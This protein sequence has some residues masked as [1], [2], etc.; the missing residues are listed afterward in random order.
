[1]KTADGGGGRPR[2][3]RALT[4][5]LT[6]T[7]RGLGGHSAAGGFPPG[8]PVPE[9]THPAFPQDVW[10]AFKLASDYRR[11]RLEAAVAAGTVESD[12]ELM[13]MPNAFKTALR[14]LSRIGGERG[15]RESVD[16]VLG[17]DRFCLLMEGY[18]IGFA[19]VPP[20]VL[21]TEGARES[22]SRAPFHELAESLLPRPHSRQVLL[23]SGFGDQIL[24]YAR[25]CR[26]GWSCLGHTRIGRIF[27]VPVVSTGRE[28]RRGFE[29]SYKWGYKVLMSEVSEAWVTTCFEEGARF[30]V[31]IAGA[32]DLSHSILVDTELRV[33]K[34]LARKRRS[35]EAR[36]AKKEGRDVRRDPSIP[37]YAVTGIASGRFEEHGPYETWRQAARF[38]TRASGP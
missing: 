12:I 16:Y 7:H 2:T 23:Y 4:S 15:E 36:A 19:N 31:A 30:A 28:S 24:E 10:R 14:E 37:F 35:E 27:S 38:L 26:S 3:D 29:L 33:L 9:R 18:S 20:R 11:Q 17:F 13:T 5:R 1:M 34:R 32:N 6:E 22:Y 25:A 21:A 8:G